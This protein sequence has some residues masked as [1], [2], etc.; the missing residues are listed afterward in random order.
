MAEDVTH[1]IFEHLRHIS[2]SQ[3]E[4]RTEMGEIKTRMNAVEATMGRM[5]SQMGD[6]QT[7]MA[8]QNARLDRIEE[9]LGRIERRSISSTINPD[10]EQTQEAV[11][12]SKRGHQWLN[13]P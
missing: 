4:M 2:S 13:S 1:L 8:V 9:R 5:Q 10:F 6:M 11:K 12:A 3:D 7:Q